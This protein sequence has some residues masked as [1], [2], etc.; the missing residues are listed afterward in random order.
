MHNQTLT[1]EALRHLE[2]QL[3]DHHICHEYQQVETTEV[4]DEFGFTYQVL[5]PTP[6][7]KCE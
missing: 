3:D 7:E 6:S 2:E 5:D 4:E 1:T